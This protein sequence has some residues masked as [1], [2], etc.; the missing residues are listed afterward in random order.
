MLVEAAE[1]QEADRNDPIAAQRCLGDALR[2]RP[3]DPVLRLRYREVCALVAHN[4]GRADFD[5]SEAASATHATTLPEGRAPSLDLGLPSES[6][7]PD[8]DDD[9]IHRVEEL[10]QRIVADPTDDNAATELASLLEA[11]GRGH[12]LLALLSARLE[13]AP[14][15]RKAELA[16]RTRSALERLADESERAGRIDEAAMYRAAAAVLSP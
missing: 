7:G 12:E 8:D 11:L 10:K 14:A 6:P 4:A 3:Q 9:R 1:L 5:A 16:A 13:D 2:L 15:E